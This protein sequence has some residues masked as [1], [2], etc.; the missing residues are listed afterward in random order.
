M[1]VHAQV[2]KDVRR[3]AHFQTYY[4]DVTCS[5]N[6]YKNHVTVGIDIPVS[7]PRN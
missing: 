5:I 6:N 3:T 7:D 4:K 1:I 2:V